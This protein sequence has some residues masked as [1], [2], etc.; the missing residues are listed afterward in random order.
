MEQKTHMNGLYLYS[1]YERFWHWFQMLLISILI[2]TGLEIHG[3]YS[4]LGFEKAVHVHNFTGITW[5][6][7]FFIFIF[8]LF[9]TGEWK[10]YIPTTKKIM[11]VVKYYLVDIFRGKP[12]P[13]KKSIDAKHNP[14]QRISYLSVISLLL[15]IQMF[16]GI[17]YYTYNE[18]QIWG[19][20]FLTLR[21]TALLHV[22]VSFLILSFIIIHVYMT[23]TGHTPLSYIKGMI[24]GWEKE[25]L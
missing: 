22:I 19:Q 24:T 10:Q 6:V 8:W 23:T 14:L 7:S 21:Q 15:P 17:L 25:K 20:N 1:R 16:T 12:N 18:W 9:T 13:V 11:A 5:L 3:S 2:V 4:L